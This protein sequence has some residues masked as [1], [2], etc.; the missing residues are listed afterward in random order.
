MIRTNWNTIRALCNRSESVLAAA[1]NKVSV[2]LLPTYVVAAW[3]GVT[4]VVAVLGP[5]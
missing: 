1:L 2:Q 4:A 5:R 3:N